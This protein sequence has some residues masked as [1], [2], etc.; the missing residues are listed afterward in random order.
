[1]SQAEAVPLMVPDPRRIQVLF[2]GHGVAESTD[3]VVVRGADARAVW[4]FP[5][6]DVEMTVLEPAGRGVPPGHDGTAALFTIYRD[7]HV[8]EA[9]AWSFDDPPAALR[10]IAG[11]IAFDPAH[12]DFAVEGEAPAEWALAHAARRSPPLPQ[13]AAFASA[14][15][16][17]EALRRAAAA[18]ELHEAR[19]GARDP[20]WPV[21]YAAFLVAEQDEPARIP[22]RDDPRSPR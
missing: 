4:Y 5:R 15:D 14:Q 12:F 17:A 21:W 9:A 1:M 11:H 18:H 16:L 8:V 7:A 19:L 2:G 13:A 6:R 10:A 3:A 22:P 20:D